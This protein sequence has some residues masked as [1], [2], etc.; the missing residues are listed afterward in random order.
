MQ[1]VQDLGGDVMV[2][3]KTGWEKKKNGCEEKKKHSLKKLR[4]SR[5]DV[6][7]FLAKLFCHTSCSL[8]T[9]QHTH[10]ARI[11]QCCAILFHHH[12]VIK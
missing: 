1:N 5:K 9:C 7:H 11:L 12:P 6:L 8:H 2:G 10:F 4:L 3:E